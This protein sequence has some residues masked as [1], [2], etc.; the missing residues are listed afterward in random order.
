MELRRLA[1]DM[2]T[3]GIRL[4]PFPLGPLW[5]HPFFPFEIDEFEELLERGRFD[6]LEIDYWLNRWVRDW[7]EPEERWWRY[8]REWF[9]EVLRA[10]QRLIERR[11]VSGVV[12]L[13]PTGFEEEPEDYE[14]QQISELLPP[15][16]VL[17][18]EVGRPERKERPL[19][20]GIR[21]LR[22]PENRDE[23]IDALRYLVHDR[24]E[25]AAAAPPRPP[26]SP[27][28][29]PD[30]PMPE[31]R[32]PRYE[33]PTA[34][35]P[36]MRVSPTRRVMDLAVRAKSAMSSI[37]WKARHKP[38]ADAVHLGASAPTRVRP[39]D[40]FTARFSAYHPAFAKVAKKAL[41]QPGAK[42]D[43]DQFQTTWKL[44]EE[45]RVVLVGEHMKASPSEQ[46]FTWEGTYKTVQF[47]VIADDSVV[48]RRRVL[49]RFDVYIQEAVVA[50]VRLPLTI[51]S[52]PGFLEKIL[53]PEE[54]FLAE[55]APQTAYASYE[56]ADKTDVMQRID[57]IAQH[58]GIR[59]FTEC[60]SL[61]PNEERE[62][63][64]RKTIRAQDLFMLFWSWAAAK[65][66]AV[67]WEWTTALTRPGRERMEV[68][69]LNP[70]DPEPVLP[71]ELHD[72]A[73]LKGQVNRMQHTD[74]KYFVVGCVLSIFVAGLVIWA[75]ALGTLTPDQRTLMRVLLSLFSG[76]A[77]GSF[78]G[79][80][81]VKA[82]GLIPGVAATAT[83]GFGVWLLTAFFMLPNA[84]TF[85]IV[86]QPHG[87]AGILD[88]FTEGTVSLQL[89]EQLKRRTIDKDGQARFPD[90][91]SK[92]EGARVP[93]RAQ[94]PG[95]EM[96]EPQ[97]NV[98]LRQ[99]EALVVPMVPEHR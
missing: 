40:E 9:P 95:F 76:F 21:S 77:A 24:G 46:T 30:E 61:D 63:A 65:S 62:K 14:L 44:G 13:T 4:I 92:F 67:K 12:I 57:A 33:R 50:R 81:T 60:L 37:L 89:G 16:S 17:H 70:N 35:A 32:M 54:Q 1:E 91:L 15:R 99:G 84:S 74:K 86:V 93:I 19:F 41:S 5:Y 90:I 45:V 68:Q 20:P 36:A 88:T 3:E 38:E 8:H 26:P 10:A 51:D 11:L 2:R 64:L 28:T 42:T 79:A 58:A 85:D 73:T 56:T 75:F 27:G 53:V 49:L 34:A 59:F 23:I 18:L 39:G 7:P 48:E 87:P 97:Q 52:K 80:F 22:Y 31:A 29:P 71:A 66:S 69:R 94:I 98:E 25:G 82:R 47:D 78:V 83:G 72:L 96:K 55:P 6:W 43:P